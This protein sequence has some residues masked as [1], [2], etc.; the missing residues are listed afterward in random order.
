MPNGSGTV[1]GVTADFS[2]LYTLLGT[3][4]GSAGTL[5]DLQGSFVRG[6]TSSDSG[7][8]NETL[9]SD[10][11]G[12]S[13]NPDP[14]RDRGSHQAQTTI[15]HSH[16]YAETDHQHQLYNQIGNPGNSV[17]GGSGSD[18]SSPLS[19][20]AQSNVVIGGIH[21]STSA[22]ANPGSIDMDK[23]STN[24]TRPTNIALLPII[25]F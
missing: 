11:P 10:H 22:S 12:A 16:D 23:V 24:E 6:W 18:T 20:G 3:T 1:Q 17:V 13:W 8:Y 2:D 19:A 25:K 21:T 4:Y 7:A 15:D 9:S 14:S 5:P